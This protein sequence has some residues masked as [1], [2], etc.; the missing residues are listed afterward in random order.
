[1]FKVFKTQV[2]NGLMWPVAII[3][4]DII[5]GGEL[6]PGQTLIGMVIL[7]PIAS[8]SDKAIC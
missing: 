7:I 3:F 8:V 1:M 6:E 5:I 2:L 4:D